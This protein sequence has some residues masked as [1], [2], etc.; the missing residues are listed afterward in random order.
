M[1]VS[2]FV[3]G[4]SAGAVE[5]KSKTPSNEFPGYNIK[6]SDGKAPVLELWGMGSTCS[7]PSLPVPLWPEVVAPDRGLCMSQW[8]L[9]GI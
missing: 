9:F 3:P 1:Q 6:L 5:F 8:E 2:I 4:Q 7:L